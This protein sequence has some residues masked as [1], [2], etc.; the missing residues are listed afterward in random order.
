MFRWVM[1]T[2]FGSAVAPDVKMISTTVSRVGVNG[3][4]AVA[5]GAPEC[6][7]AE[8]GRAEAGSA[9]IPASCQTCTASPTVPGGSST[10][11]PISTALASTI[12]ATLARNSGEAR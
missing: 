12:L 2:P 9:P 7:G 8:A 11:S 3:A 10:S 4:C 5:V 1:I 6:G